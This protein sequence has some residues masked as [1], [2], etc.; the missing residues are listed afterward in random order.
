MKEATSPSALIA[1]LRRLVDLDSQM[2]CIDQTR[3]T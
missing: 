1:A 2:P 3:T